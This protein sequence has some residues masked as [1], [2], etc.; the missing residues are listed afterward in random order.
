VAALAMEHEAHIGN[1]AVM[2]SI[3]IPVALYFL[4]VGGLYGYLVGWRPHLV[5]M[6]LIKLGVVFA[7][8]ATIYKV[9]GRAKAPL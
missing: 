6:T 9:S 8:V 5:W 3:S 4:S 2:W 7:A 1:T